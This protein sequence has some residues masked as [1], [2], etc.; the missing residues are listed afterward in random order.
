MEQIMTLERVQ[1]AIKYLQD[2]GERVSRRNVRAIT[3]GGMS[4]VHRLMSLAEEEDLCRSRLASKEIS[5]T[6]LTALR[7]E[8]TLQTKGLAQSYEQQ[9]QDLKGQEQEL[10]DAL[11]DAE[12]KSAKLEDD[13]N[14]LKESTDKSRQKTEKDLAVAKESIRRLESWQN[15]FKAERKEM[16]KTLDNLRTDNIRKTQRIETLELTVAALQMKP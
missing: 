12:E 11:E 1:N 5:G 10:I 15:E 13:L 6:F 7:S 3:G 9:I 16:V 4:T 8:I 14:L 2:H